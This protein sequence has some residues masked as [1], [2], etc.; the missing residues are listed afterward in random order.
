ML[1]FWERSGCCTSSIDGRAG[2]ALR[3]S[4]GVEL[5]HN[6]G[7]GRLAIEAS[8]TFPTFGFRASGGN[9]VYYVPMTLGA[10]VVL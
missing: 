2:I 3:A 5:W 1:F 4:A 7:H 6:A 9:D 10:R 8:A